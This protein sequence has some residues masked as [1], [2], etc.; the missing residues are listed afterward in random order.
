MVEIKDSDGKV[1]AIARDAYEHLRVD[2]DVSG[3]SMT[4]QSFKDECDINFIMARYERTGQLPLGDVQPLFGDFSNGLDLHQAMNAVSMAERNFIQNV[5]A[6]VRARFDNDPG[7][8]L[9]FA[10][11]PNNVEEMIKLGLAVRKPGA[12][13]APT[14]VPSATP[15]TPASG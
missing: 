8:F 11:D 15:S 14:A 3:E 9:D 12:E 5:P 10:L 6:D 4:K 2:T 7:K 13:A 1:V